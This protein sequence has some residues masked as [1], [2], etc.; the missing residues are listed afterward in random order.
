MRPEVD[1]TLGGGAVGAQGLAHICLSIVFSLA[2][3][4]ALSALFSPSSF[5]FLAF[6]FL[7]L[8]LPLSF[9]FVLLLSWR[10]VAPLSFASFLLHG[11]LTRSLFK[12]GTT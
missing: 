7:V 9:A 4:S 6:A 11:G 8:L 5:L 1:P 10:L 2:F 12:S 3:L